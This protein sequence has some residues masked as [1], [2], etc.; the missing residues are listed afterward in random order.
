MF[1]W[2]TCTSAPGAYMTCIP[3]HNTAY[4]P[5]CTARK[6]HRPL[7][8]PPPPPCPP[9]GQP[10]ARRRPP[11]PPPRCPPPPPPPPRSRT[12]PYLCY[13]QPRRCPRPAT[14]GSKT[15]E[16][17]CVWVQSSKHPCGSAA[18]ERPCSCRTVCHGGRRRQARGALVCGTVPVTR[19]A[20]L[21]QVA[22]L[23]QGRRL[24]CQRLHQRRLALVHLLL[25]LAVL[26]TAHAGGREAVSTGC[27]L[28]RFVTMGVGALG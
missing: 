18:G 23:Q 7:P 25:D 20:K 5:A 8:C 19:N 12:C 27:T 14:G 26:C 10:Q 17:L 6:R 24:G 28:L 15:L 13:C 11:P 2:D 4:P 9:P 16:A 22:H 1:F 21:G 3:S